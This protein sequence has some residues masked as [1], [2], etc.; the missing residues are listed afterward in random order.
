MFRRQATIFRRVG[1]TETLKHMMSL[2]HTSTT[3][4]NLLF[5]I[6]DSVG[7][8]VRALLCPVQPQAGHLR[9][10]LRLAEHHRDGQHA[11]VTP[12]I[13]YY[14]CLTKCPTL[15][16]VSPKSYFEKQ[17]R[18]EEARDGSVS[19]CNTPTGGSP[20]LQKTIFAKPRHKNRITKLTD[21]PHN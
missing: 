11:L 1:S 15:G 16:S 13:I 10:V 5:A 3:G 2:F 20:S 9:G 17:R 4:S 8:Q 6:G 14:P 7:L 12:L 18:T 19:L 21:S